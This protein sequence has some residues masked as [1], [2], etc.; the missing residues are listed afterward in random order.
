MLTGVLAPLLAVLAGSL[1]GV[2]QAGAAGSRTACANRGSGRA[3]ASRGAAGPECRRR[4]RARAA[5]GGGACGSDRRAGHAAARRGSAR[6][7]GGTRLR[8]HQCSATGEEGCRQRRQRKVTSHHLSCLLKVCSVPL[9]SAK[10]SRPEDDMEPTPGLPQRSDE[11]E[12][13][14]AVD[15]ATIALR[16]LRFGELK[17]PASNNAWIDLRQR[18]KSPGDP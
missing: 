1:V 8:Q 12:F 13:S 16:K 3:L 15:A 10:W 17:L 6:P 11:K 14:V 7:E 2:I 9:A 18:S 5:A 4:T